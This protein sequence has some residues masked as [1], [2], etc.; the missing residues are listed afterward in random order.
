MPELKEQDFLAY[1]TA[2]ACG[3]VHRGSDGKIAPVSSTSTPAESSR[4]TPV[5][6]AVANKETSGKGKKG[7][8]KGKKVVEAVEAVEGEGARTDVEAA[9]VE[10]SKSKDKGKCKTKAVDPAP[11]AVSQT[12]D[13]VP[14]V[15]PKAKQPKKSKKNKEA[16]TPAVESTNAAPETS[17]PVLSAY[18]TL[19]KEISN[20][21]KKRVAENAEAETS[22][23]PEITAEQ[24]AKF[25]P[26]KSKAART[27][28]GVEDAPAPLPPIPPAPEPSSTP[29]GPSKTSTKVAKAKTPKSTSRAKP[30]APVASPAVE[31]PT[32]AESSTPARGV[33]PRDTRALSTPVSEADV[34]R[35]HFSHVSGSGSSHD[36]PTSRSLASP[37]TPAS[38]TQRGKK[39]KSDALG[40]ETPL[41]QKVLSRGGM[42]KKRS[43]L[44]SEDLADMEM[45]DEL[46]T[47]GKSPP[48]TSEKKKKKSKKSIG[49]QEVASS[50]PVESVSVAS[51]IPPPSS[52]VVPDT[53]TPSTKPKKSGKESKRDKKEQEQREKA[54]ALEAA[55]L[56]EKE[57]AAA[58]KKARK[59]QEK[60]EKKER[61][62]SKADAT[63]VSQPPK[64][65]AAAPD[66]LPVTTPAKD[67]P[68]T[69]ASKKKRRL[70]DLPI[71]RI[72][73]A[74]SPAV[75]S[76]AETG[77]P[78]AVKKPRKSVPT[79]PFG[80]GQP[81]PA[82]MH[83]YATMG[84]VTPS[85]KSKGAG[86]SKKEKKK[87]P[88][89]ITETPKA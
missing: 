23:T 24:P 33:P 41:R 59:E 38:P 9:N 83:M 3:L 65:P 35:Y 37:G 30:I 16:A 67:T 51:P 47:P 18:E 28:V 7:G 77:S 60:K 1:Y 63:S 85:P 12:T 32:L 57:K 17:T 86:S 14:P 2:I 43:S 44:D 74:K 25:K 69:P 45:V 72:T 56:E 79:T 21:A 4:Q 40:A 80:Q 13:E 75:T 87:G 31:S 39:R 84:V 50:A 58:E 55:E 20:K 82:V 8:R 26:R 6:D 49:G 76:S 68:I 27:P 70:T 71:P 34:Y 36:S 19:A 62:K 88:R 73:P 22:R 54:L 52:P 29:S 46:A 64:S 10:A 81:E 11:P 15:Q 89:W 66:P 48:S 42:G 61:R 5:L 53:S 78:S